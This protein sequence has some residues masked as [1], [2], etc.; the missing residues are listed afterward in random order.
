MFF[1]IVGFLAVFFVLVWVS[2][3]YSIIFLNG[4][5]RYNIGGAFNKRT[6]KFLILLAGAL[7]CFCWYKLFQHSPFSF[8]F[9][10]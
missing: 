6:Q 4:M 10:V 3:G 7:L 5:G 2:L 9:K 8:S 1:N